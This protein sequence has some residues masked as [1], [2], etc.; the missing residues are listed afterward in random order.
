LY[1]TT[2]SG[3]Q[4]K[5]AAGI[6]VQGDLTIRNSTISGNRASS[7]FGGIVA[8]GFLGTG[9]FTLDNST[10]AFNSHGSNA[11]GAGIQVRNGAVVNSSIIANNTSFLDGNA[12]DL[13]V[14]FGTITGGYNLIG[15]ANAPLPPGTLSGNPHLG[16]LA[17]NGGPTFTHALK[18]A[19][20]AIDNGINLHGLA[21][22]QRQAG[23]P[24]VIGTS[25]DIGAFELNTNDVIFSDGFD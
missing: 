19:S 16:L 24:R 2:I 21:F 12:Y 4:A 14:Y 17:D 23:H 25:A 7:M 10:V 3:N 8:G 15:T 1:A 5:F 9:V 20:P 18:S 6:Y 22:D 13:D 11:P